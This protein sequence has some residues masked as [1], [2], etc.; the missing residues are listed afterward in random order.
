M[1]LNTEQCKSTFLLIMN[2]LSEKI[3]YLKPKETLCWLQRQGCRVKALGLLTRTNLT[4]LKKEPFMTMI[5]VVFKWEVLLIQDEIWEAKREVYREERHHFPV[6]PKIHLT[7]D[8]NSIPYQEQGKAPFLSSYQSVSPSSDFSW[9]QYGHFWN[10]K[11]LHR[12]RQLFSKIR[13]A[14]LIFI[15]CWL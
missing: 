11:M 9:V 2:D 10:W 8:W 13:L 7:Y 1:A 15:Q 14:A 6:W 12:K 3:F 4:A 5:Y